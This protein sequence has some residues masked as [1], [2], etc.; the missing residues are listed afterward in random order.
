LVIRDAHPDCLAAIRS[1]TDLPDGHRRHPVP[2]LAFII[3]VA[4]DARY[5]MLLVPRLREES[6]TNARVIVI[7]TIANTGS[8]I[9]SAGLIFA[10]S[11]FGLLVGLG[12]PQ[13]FDRLLRRNRA[14]ARHLR[15]TDDHR[16]SHC[17]PAAREELVAQ[18]FSTSSGNWRLM[19]ERR[20]EPLK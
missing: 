7:R 15:R 5:N 2:I 9:W 18:P 3:L 10:A 17:H 16:P 11:M 6:T 20:S 1:R 4:V 8:V 12:N 13:A 19:S 14:P